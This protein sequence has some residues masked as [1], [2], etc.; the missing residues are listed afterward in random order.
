MFDIPLRKG[1][2]ETRGFPEKE[3]IKNRGFL[4]SESEARRAPAKGWR[5]RA[6]KF[7]LLL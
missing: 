4:K 2:G 7:E 1:V 3:N 6:T 5:G